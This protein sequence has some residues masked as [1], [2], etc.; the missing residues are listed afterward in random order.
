[1]RFAPFHWTMEPLIK[2]VPLTVSINAEPPAVAETGLRL[3]VVGKGLLITL[4][5][6]VCAFEVPPPGAGVNTVTVAIPAV[7]M[8][9]ASIAAVNWVVDK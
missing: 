6:K 8:S 3:V 1:M 4:I 5:V 2:P 7:A 9:A